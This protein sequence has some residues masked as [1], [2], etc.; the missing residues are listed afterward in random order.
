VSRDAAYADEALALPLTRATLAAAEELRV[1][2]PLASLLRKR[3]LSLLAH[4][5]KQL[6]WSAIDRLSAADAGMC[7]LG[8]KI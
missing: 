7:S 5:G 6:D 2:M 4:G 8:R 3:F 1:P